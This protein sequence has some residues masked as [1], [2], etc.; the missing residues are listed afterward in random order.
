MRGGLLNLRQE[1]DPEEIYEMEQ[2]MQRRQEAYHSQLRR[3]LPQTRE[4]VI[5]DIKSYV[6][7][8]RRQRKFA[9]LES[10]FGN[11]GVDYEEIDQFLNQGANQ[12]ANVMS[13]DELADISDALD[14]MNNPEDD[15]IP[16]F[17]E[18]D[19]M[20]TGLDEDEEEEETKD[21]VIEEPITGRRR[22]RDEPPDRDRSRQ[23]LDFG[24]GLRQA[25]ENN[26]FGHKSIQLGVR[27]LSL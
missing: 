26:V 16:N 19:M 6:R 12:G 22:Q 25:M 7:M 13:F 3:Q 9:F 27:P 21:D 24:S 5:D 4:E 17:L 18:T 23:R 20:D 1:Y 2:D 11:Y 10:I 15:R 14:L 8:L